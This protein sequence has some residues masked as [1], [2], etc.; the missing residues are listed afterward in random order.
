V[1][2]RRLELEADELLRL[3]LV[4]DD[5]IGLAAQAEPQRLA[6]GVEHREDALPAGLAQR[7]RVPVLGHLARVG[8]PASTTASLPPSR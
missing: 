1:I 3:H 8:L 2:L 7:G 4:G 6:L 5:Q